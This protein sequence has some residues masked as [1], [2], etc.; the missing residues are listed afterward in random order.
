M[1][2]LNG[3]RISKNI[4]I[5]TQGNLNIA[6]DVNS[7]SLHIID[8]KTFEFI[9]D[10]ISRQVEKADIHNDVVKNAGSFLTQ[11]EKKSILSELAELQAQN[12]LFSKELPEI[13]PQYNE[14]PII[15]AICLHVAHDCNLRC[16]Y[17]FADTGHFGGSRGLMDFETGKNAL[18]FLLTSCGDRSHCEVDFFGGEPLLNFKVIQEL[19]SYGKKTAAQKGKTMKFTMTTNAVLLDTKKLQYLEEE[20]ISIVLSL[21]GRKEINDRMRPYPNGKGSYDRIIPRILDFT[22][23]REQ[24]SPYA[25]GK[26]YYVRGTY[27]HYNTDFYKDVLHMADLGINRISLEP[28]VACAQEEYAF[29][30][31]DLAKIYDSYDI[32]ADKV[33]DYKKA[34]KEFTFFH[35]N[36]GLDEGPCIYKRLTGCGAGSEY[37]AVSPA[38]DIYPCHQF[39][40][41]EEYKMGSVHNQEPDLRESIIEAFRKAHIYAKEEC[42]ECWARFSCSGGCHASNIAFS[43]ELTKVYPLGCKLQKKRL[44]TA[45][46]LKVREAMEE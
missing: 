34:G 36:A 20:N 14:K 30:E 9:K 6:Y 7:G 39:V 32:L 22:K 26:Y 41:Q 40:G 15:K 12:L 46:Y 1:L 13:R 24:S 21:D 44:E 25:V 28:V 23:S 37:I 3:Y 45:Y 43:G 29:Q 10:L 17:C 4:H 19:V 8:T 18:N 33:L 27:T 42:K 16:R 35:F 2:N 38:G 5:Y 11:E 31:E